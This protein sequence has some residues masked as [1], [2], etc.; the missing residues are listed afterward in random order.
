MLTSRHTVVAGLLSL[1]AAFPLRAQATNPSPQT[2]GLVPIPTR[3]YVGFNPVGLPADIATFEIESAVAPGITIGGVA[4][5]MDISDTRFTT[6][7]FKVRYYPGEVVLRDWSLGATAGYTRISNLVGGT[8]ETLDAPTLGVVLDRNWL[9]GRSKR[10]LIGT[11]IGAKRLI[12]SSADRDRVDVERAIMTV[13]LIVGF[14][15]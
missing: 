7:D 14:A 12:A 15:F 13:R 2:P 10:F 5:Y 4:S 9:Y 6:F 8:R 3:T 1:L 11:G